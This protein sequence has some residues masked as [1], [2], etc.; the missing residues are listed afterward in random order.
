MLRSWDALGSGCSATALRLNRWVVSGG[1][2]A[3][4]HKRPALPDNTGTLGVC[5]LHGALLFPARSVQAGEMSEIAL[6]SEAQHVRSTQA[7]A[8]WAAS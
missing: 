8:A 7:Q 5:C 1:V 6:P 4:F 2:A 3:L